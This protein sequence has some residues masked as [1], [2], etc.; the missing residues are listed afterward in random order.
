MCATGSKN[1]TLYGGIDFSG[2]LMNDVW[3]YDTGIHINKDSVLLFPWF[4]F[5]FFC[6]LLFSFVFFSLV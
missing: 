5:V 6:F 4:S 3:A 1:L 2:N